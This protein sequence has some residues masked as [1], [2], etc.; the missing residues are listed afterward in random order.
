M[1]DI[2]LE[3]TRHTA[4][5][6]CDESDIKYHKNSQEYHIVVEKTYLLGITERMN[7][8]GWTLAWKKENIRKGWDKL[9]FK[10]NSQLQTH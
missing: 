5:E 1:T 7:K 10:H 4:L 2:L 8:L 9:A 3:N 6:F